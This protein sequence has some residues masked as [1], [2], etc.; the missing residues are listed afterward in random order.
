MNCNFSQKRQLNKILRIILIK[1]FHYNGNNNVLSIIKN[2]NIILH[3]S[4]KMCGTT[5]EKPG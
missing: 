5:V 3:A 4:K 2:T 1:M